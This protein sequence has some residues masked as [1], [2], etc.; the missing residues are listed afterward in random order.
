MAALRPG[1]AASSPADVRLR[2]VPAGFDAL[3]REHEAALAA[4][5]RRLCGSRADGDDLVQECLERALRRFD[6]FTP[7]THGRAW[8][9][10]ILHHAFIDRC[11]RRAADKRIDGV[12]AAEVAAPEPASPPAWASVTAEQF[13]RAIDALDEDFR[14]VYRM[15]AEGRSYQDISA[16][17]GIPVATVGTRLNRARTKLRRL[18]ESALAAEEQ[19]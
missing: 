4:F 1:V 5:A 12:D 13:A 15:H 16:T 3:V 19:S 9:F 7:G 11:R 6:S 17:L 2:A 8:L 10:T 14:G 18:L